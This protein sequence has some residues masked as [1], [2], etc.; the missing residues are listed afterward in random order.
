MEM[1]SVLN[2]FAAE[3]GLINCPKCG[4]AQEKR[5]D[6]KKCGIV[7]SK[8]YA[9]YPTSRTD[10]V[11]S[12]ETTNTPVLSG[13][14]LRTMIEELQIQ[15][16]T[17]SNL[18]VQ[19]EFEKAE[20]NQLRLDLKNLERQLVENVGRLENRLEN[21]PAPQAE[22]QLFDPRLPELRD[23]LAQAEATLGSFEFAGQYMVELSEKGETN[24]RQIGDLRNQVTILREDL[25]S[26]K[27]QLD[28]IAE[29]Q[30][31]E[32]PRTPLEEDVHVIRQNLD[33]LRAFLRK[34]AASQ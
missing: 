6:C 27:R 5:L 19:V 28:S 10:D 4:F 34:P 24:A 2:G 22:E 26:I 12:A 13:Q 31:A 18:C 11:N 7:F 33:E 14:D 25:D 30:K 32:E 1:E 17:L 9:L 29:A 16:Q 20:R 3:A 21:V 15:V 23:R 8:Y